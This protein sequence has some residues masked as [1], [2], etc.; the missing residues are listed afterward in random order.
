MSSSA[1]G[2]NRAPHNSADAAR[3]RHHRGDPRPD[4]SP[5]RFNLMS[6]LKPLPAAWSHQR[7]KLHIPQELVAKTRQSGNSLIP[8]YGCKCAASPQP[9]ADR[10]SPASALSDR[11]LRVDLRLVLRGLTDLYS[12][13]FAGVIYELRSPTKAIHRS[14]VLGALTE[15]VHG[16]NRASVRG[17]PRS[18]A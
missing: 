9:A 17:V 16:K 4:A 10:I 18:A 6:C 14:N 11:S 12:V 8:C 1:L 7:S 15:K 13:S 5:P 3:A 2:S